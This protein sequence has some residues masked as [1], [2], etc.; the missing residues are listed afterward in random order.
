MIHIAKPI[1]TDEEIKAVTETLK[2]GMIAQGPKV[3]LFQK[4]FS[5]FVST[6]Y[7]IAT[8]SEQQRYTQ[9]YWLWE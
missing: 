9:H 2:S 3:D 4:E 5:K 6:K 1:I 8:S 7:G